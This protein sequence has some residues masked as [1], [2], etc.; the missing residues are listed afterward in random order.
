M[1]RNLHLTK[2]VKQRGFIFPY[3]CFIAIMLLLCVLT[4]VTLYEN[5]KQMTNNQLEQ[6]K[7]ETLRQMTSGKLF[8]EIRHQKIKLPFKDIAYEFPNGSATVQYQTHDSEVLQVR[9][10]TVTTRGYTKYWNKQ[11]EMNDK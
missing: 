8:D 10:E 2:H 4:S 3:I 11:I 1:L 5:S 6:I 9:I 7:L